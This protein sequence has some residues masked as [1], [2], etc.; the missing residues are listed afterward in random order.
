M[1]PSLG[2]DGIQPLSAQAVAKL[3]PSMGPSL[4]GDGIRSQVR[5]N[6]AIWFCLQWGRRSVATESSGNW[7]S[8]HR[9]RDLQWG[10]RSVATESGGSSQ[11]DGA[12]NRPSM[13]PSLGGDGICGRRDSGP[14]LQYPSM[15]PSLGGDGIEAQE[16][17]QTSA[18]RPSM[19]PSLGGDGILL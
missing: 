7:R 16:A 10:R 1:G 14:A 19:G 11:R 4:G 3:Y 17:S 6:A 18:E 5:V 12:I 8:V 13:G 2:G 9:K 15:G